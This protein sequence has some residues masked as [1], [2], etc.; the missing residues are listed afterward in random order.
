M[1]WLSRNLLLLTFWA[2]NF[3]VMKCQSR[4]RALVPFFRSCVCLSLFKSVCLRLSRDQIK[5]SLSRQLLQNLVNIEEILK[6]A[7]YITFHL[8][9]TSI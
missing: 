8:G 5:K 4:L 1:R 9:L 3:G 6:I 2:D 7:G